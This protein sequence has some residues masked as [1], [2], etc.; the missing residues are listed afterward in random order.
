VRRE[1]LLS[2]SALV[3]FAAAG[4]GDEPVYRVEN[5]V[6]AFAVTNR[7]PQAARPAPAESD[8][9]G[10]GLDEVN[11][12][13]AERGLRPFLRDE[14]LTRAAFGAARF[15][16]R[17]LLFGH[18]ANDFAF[19]PAGASADS[20][21][22]AAYPAGYGWL[23]CCTYEGYT[24][25]GAAYAVGADGKRY[26]HLYV[27]SGG[28]AVQV[29][30]AAPVA[31]AATTPADDPRGV[32]SPWWDGSQWQPRWVKGGAPV[33]GVPFGRG[34]TAPSAGGASTSSPGTTATAPTIT[35]VPRGTPGG[36]N[37]PPFG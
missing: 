6:P 10:D 4:R 24:H 12:K 26:M 11:A 34:T 16:A 31:P 32:W 3:V 20:A 21:G 13:R 36:T 1:F 29:A 23:S 28:P 2:V 25:A 9:A 18:T 14:S 19:L 35:L 30:P 15:R 33:S 27:R 17:H 22:C 37:C 5:R 8:Q 7:V